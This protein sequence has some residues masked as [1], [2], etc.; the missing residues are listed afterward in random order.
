MQRMAHSLGVHQRRIAFT[1]RDDVAR[2]D[3]RKQLTKAP[4]AARIL[5]KRR[6]SARLP[7]FLEPQAELSWRPTPLGIDNLQQ[8]RT[9]AATEQGSRRGRKGAA[10]YAAECVCNGWRVGEGRFHLHY[11]AFIALL[12]SYFRGYRHLWSQAE[13][14]REVALAKEIVVD[15]AY[16]FRRRSRRNRKADTQFACALGYGDHAYLAGCHGGKHAA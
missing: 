10:A 8:F 13:G 14:N 2:L 11:A 6:A 4:H 15:R 9:L 5:W 1:H 16:H 7:Y 12:S 3:L